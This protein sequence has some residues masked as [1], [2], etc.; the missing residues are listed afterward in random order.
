MCVWMSPAS[1]GLLAPAPGPVAHAVSSN[2]HT[3]GAL[4][5][6]ALRQE[7]VRRSSPMF[8]MNVASVA[9][10]SHGV[11][12]RERS[13]RAGACS[14]ASAAR[15]P[16]RTRSRRLPAWAVTRALF[17]EAGKRAS[18]SAS[19]ARR[20]SGRQCAAHAAYCSVGARGEGGEL[21]SYGEMAWQGDSFGISRSRVP[22]RPARPVQGAG[23]YKGHVSH[24]VGGWREG[25]AFDAVCRPVPGVGGWGATP[26]W[27]VG[28]WKMHWAVAALQETAIDKRAAGG[29]LAWRT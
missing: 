26:E 2:T 16:T 29:P 22:S 5:A 14:G 25:A 11:T 7:R 19:A 24:T 21:R 10:F 27:L 6:A 23:L 1:A 12:P 28:S 20:G 18:R 13:T 17:S 3:A 8:P 4:A 9:P 15:A